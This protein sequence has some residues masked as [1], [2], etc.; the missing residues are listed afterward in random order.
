MLARIKKERTLNYSLT[1]GQTWTEPSWNTNWKIRSLFCRVARELPIRPPCMRWGRERERERA[2]TCWDCVAHMLALRLA[3]NSQFGKVEHCRVCSAGS[4]AA[5]SL[6]LHG[7]CTLASW[8]CVWLSKGERRS[9]GKPHWAVTFH[10]KVHSR[11]CNW[12]SVRW[13]CSYTHT[14]VHKRVSSSPQD[15]DIQTFSAFFFSSTKKNAAGD[16]PRGIQVPQTRS[17]SMAVDG[18]VCAQVVVAIPDTPL[19]KW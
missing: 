9:N 7:R 5:L 8:M 4:A 3:Q 10:L 11:R 6:S 2:G 18:G 15:F 12:P 19:S 1:S 17:G 13:P 14:P 16:R